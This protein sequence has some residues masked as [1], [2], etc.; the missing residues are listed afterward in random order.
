VSTRYACHSNSRSPNDE[1]PLYNKVIILKLILTNGYEY[2]LQPNSYELLCSYLYYL[3]SCHR[4]FSNCSVA[5]THVPSYY[6]HHINGFFKYFLSN[7]W[8][9]I[10]TKCIFL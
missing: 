7:I 1:T 4:K 9:A 2:S 6:I 8:A 3:K 5:T 10:F